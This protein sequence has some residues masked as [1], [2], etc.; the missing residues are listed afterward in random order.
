MII[1]RESARNLGAY[2]QLWTT[3]YPILIIFKKKPS[4][5]IHF[6]GFWVQHPVLTSRVMAWLC[7]LSYEKLQLAP[8]LRAWSD[9]L[10]P[11]G[12]PG[13]ALGARHGW[14]SEDFASSSYA[15]ELS[16]SLTRGLWGLWPGINGKGWAV[17]T[18]WSLLSDELLLVKNSFHMFSSWLLDYV[19]NHRELR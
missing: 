15:T 2:H 9:G 18:M 6:W 14:Y 12:V 7:Y 19:V 13:L 11:P 1:N 17:V 16:R 3:P 8:L 4:Q 10:S 5:T